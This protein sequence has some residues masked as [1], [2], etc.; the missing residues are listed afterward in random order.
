MK[1]ELIGA[2][3]CMSS[4]TLEAEIRD[5]GFQV[6]K[7]TKKYPYDTR[8]GFE[9]VNKSGAPLWFALANGEDLAMSSPQKYVFRLDD[10]AARMFSIDT[11]DVTMLGIWYNQPDEIAMKN[12]FEASKPPLIYKFTPDKTVYVT[13]RSNYTL[14]PETG[15]LKGKSG[16]TASHLSLESNV[17]QADIKKLK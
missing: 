9:L 12:P 17:V 13:F 1:I 5:E 4:F 16:R 7:Q 2:I 14:T 10:K 15:T 6:F 3:L 11:Y 8:V